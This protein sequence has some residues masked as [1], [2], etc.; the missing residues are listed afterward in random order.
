MI[1]IYVVA[2]NR[3]CGDF[4]SARLL[5]SHYGFLNLEGLKVDSVFISSFFV[6]VKCFLHGVMQT[7]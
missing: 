5:L 1:V 6:S 7:F 4:K 2:I 3:V